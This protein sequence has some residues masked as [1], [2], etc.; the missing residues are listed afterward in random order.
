MLAAWAR[1][2]DGNLFP[3]RRSTDF[4]LNFEES[5]NKR[6]SVAITVAS[7]QARRQDNQH[8]RQN[9]RIHSKQDYHHYRNSETEHNYALHPQSVS[10]QK[11]KVEEER[12]RRQLQLSDERLSAL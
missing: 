8:H 10:E 3:L 11:V 2:T 1:G 5:I 7:Q 4:K 12:T 9:R 6:R